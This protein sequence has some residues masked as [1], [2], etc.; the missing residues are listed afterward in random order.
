M[1]VKL[2]RQP[3]LALHTESATRFFSEDPDLSGAC[4]ADEAGRVASITFQF[5]E[6]EVKARR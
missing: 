4:G 5:G 3:E 2:P 1:F 6:R